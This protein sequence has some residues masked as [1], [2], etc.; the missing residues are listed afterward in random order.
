MRILAVLVPAA[1]LLGAC[2]TTNITSSAN[3]SHADVANWAD[4]A[5]L[6]VELHGVVPGRTKAEL[7]SLFPAYHPPQY[8][9]LGAL[10]PSDS[11]R[12]MV[13]FV[14]P[15]A[16]LDTDTLCA[17]RGH[18]ERGVQQGGSAFVEGALCEGTR[19]IS[20]ASARVLTQDMTPKELAYNFAIIRDQLYQTLFPGANNPGRYYD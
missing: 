10:P 13:L 18:F 1:S 17:G 2:A 7:A 5:S 15:V 4:Y 12:R 19:V 9:A 16:P 3:P 11:G 14:N 6:P 20:T 8:A